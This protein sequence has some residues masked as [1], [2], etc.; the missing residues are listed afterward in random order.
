MSDNVNHFARLSA[1][2]VSEHI[3]KKGGFKLPEL[4]VRVSQLRLADPAAC[5]RSAAST[6]CPT[7]PARSASSSRS[8]F[9]VQGVTLSQIHPVLD[10]RNR[11]ILAPTAFDIN[12]SI[13]RCL[14]KAIALHGLGL[15]IYAGEDLPQIGTDPAANDPAPVTP[16]IPATPAVPVG[17]TIT[18]APA[19]DDP[20]AHRRGRRRAAAGARVFRR[21]GPG[22]IPVSNYL[23]VVRSLEKRRPHEPDRPT[24]AGSEQWHAHRR[25]LRNASETPAVLGL[26]PWVTPY[27]LWLL[28]TGRAE[29]AVNT[30][31]HRGTALE[32]LARHA[33]EVE[34]GL[35]MQPL[36]LQDGLYSASLD[37]MTLAG[38]LIVEIKCPY[39][40]A[41]SAL[42]QSVEGG[43]VPANYLAQVQHQLMVSGASQGAPVGLRRAARSA[44][45]PSSRMRQRRSR[46]VPRGR[47]SRCSWTPTRHRRWSK[48]M[49][50]SGTM[51]AGTGRPWRSSAPSGRSRQPRPA[52]TPPER[53][54][55]PWRRIQRRWVPA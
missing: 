7:W 50:G 48:R 36:V 54:W 11:P 25:G 40:G 55:W 2:N 19:G 21:A 52:W 43:E 16:A 45:I 5:W 53:H 13:Q 28:K 12:T 10:S 29:Q 15:Y 38:D 51:R 46:S 47:R 6:A 14:V 27:Q 30:A 42:W 3:E 35:V 18:A 17:K 49:R 9:T 22:E 31:M 8:R 39:K 23:R 37:G 20:Q 4:A 44:C 24:R 41:A 1:I 32:P 34:T 26:S 33:Y